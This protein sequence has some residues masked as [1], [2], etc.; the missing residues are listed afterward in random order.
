MRTSQCQSARLV[1]ETARLRKI[2][3]PATPAALQFASSRS[4]REA[5]IANDVARAMAAARAVADL[6][7]G[8]VGR[9]F[10]RTHRPMPAASRRYSWPL[11]R[12]AADPAAEKRRNGETAHIQT[13]E[14]DAGSSSI[15]CGSNTSTSASAVGVTFMQGPCRVRGAKILAAGGVFQHFDQAP[16][17]GE[18]RR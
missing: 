14:E 2:A 3:I 10:S 1:L 11:G 6:D 15:T 8:Q 9:I 5:P 17:A 12:R 13:V 16:G 7:A 4:R 18:N